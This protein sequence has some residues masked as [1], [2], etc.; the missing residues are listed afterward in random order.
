MISIAQMRSNRWRKPGS[1]IETLVHRHPMVV[2]VVMIEF[3]A[4]ASGPALDRLTYTFALLAMAA[5]AWVASRSLAIPLALGSV[6]PL[7][8]AIVG[9]D[10]LP[11]GGF[12]F[13]FAAWI[14]LAVG[15][16]VIR[17]QHQLPVK[18]LMCVPALASFALLGLMLLRLG[19]SPD[20]SY[21]SMKVQLYVA[22]VLIFFVGAVFV[23]ARQ[24]EIE[25]FVKVSFFVAAAGALLFLFNLIVGTAQPL[26]GG[27][28][29]LAAQEYPIEL[30]RASSDGLLIAIY[31][32]LCTSSRRL[33]LLALACCPLLAVAMLAA[34]VSRT[35]GRVRARPRR[36]AD[37]DRC[38]R[39]RPTQTHARGGCVHRCGN[40][41]PADRSRLGGRSVAFGDHRQHQRPVEQRTLGA[42]DGRDLDLLTALRLRP[43][44]GWVRIP[45]HRIALSAQHLS[46]V[47]QR[48]RNRRFAAAVRG[49]RRVGAAARKSV[50][51]HDW[52]GQAAGGTAQRAVP[53]GADQR[54]L[55]RRGAGQQRSLA[56]GG[57]RDRHERKARTG[58]CRKRASIAT[59]TSVLRLRVLMLARDAGLR[60][61]GAEVLVYEFA[62]R[63]DRERFKPYLCTTRRPDPSRQERVAQ[64]TRILRTSGAEVLS[65][66][67]NSSASITPWARLYSLLVRER[68]DIVHAH[69]PRA[70]V[71]GAILGG[72]RESP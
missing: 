19:V 65:L 10:P 61:G 13:L 18:A 54:V 3:A 6:P 24:V 52:C 67:R 34:G 17:G 14:A 60:S 12:T 44:L 57:H 28:Y 69:M 55:L 45:R 26:V 4:L 48:A 66:D 27:R 16:I 15:F 36:P 33:R 49:D 31:L 39:P 68:I 58:R 59:A 20:E 9:Y 72:L 38:G 47:R 41:R 51:E 42:L 53:D 70:S 63:L 8:D 64:E 40:P 37:V 5:G 25:T 50:A 43:R 7:V 30:G 46:R 2:L 56:L 71:P 62:R 29:S 22:D 23:G 21:G 32:V 1:W 35:G 11:K